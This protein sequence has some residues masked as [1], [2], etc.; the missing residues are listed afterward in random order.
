MTNANEISNG[1]SILAQGSSPE[2]EILCSVCSGIIPTWR[3]V[4]FIPAGLVHESC[5][6]GAL[7][8]VRL[9]HKR[10]HLGWS[11]VTM[12]FPEFL[13]WSMWCNGI[14]MFNQKKGTITVSVPERYL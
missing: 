3:E 6:P 11:D 7:A 9:F 8:P 10:C 13:A 1:N 4:Y 5:S 2:Q 12:P 14:G